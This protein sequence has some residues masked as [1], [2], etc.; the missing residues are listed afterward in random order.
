V[1]EYYVLEYIQVL[2]SVL[3]VPLQVVIGC[4]LGI[5]AALHFANSSTPEVKG[6]RSDTVVRQ[7][8]AMA[9]PYTRWLKSVGVVL[10]LGV[11]AGSFL[12]LQDPDL[13]MFLVRALPL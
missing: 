8:K 10:G 5:V 7:A 3:D 2:K 1:P 12:Y 13:F 6:A 11:S 9:T 4:P